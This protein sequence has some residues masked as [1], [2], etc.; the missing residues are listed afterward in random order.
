MGIWTSI[1]LTLGGILVSVVLKFSE[2]R[3]AIAKEKFQ[4]RL[5]AYEQITLYAYRLAIATIVDPNNQEAKEIAEEN[6]T[7][8]QKRWLEVLPLLPDKISDKVG[9]ILSKH[10]DV[11]KDGASQDEK[12]KLLGMAG[13]LLGAIKAELGTGTDIPTLERIFLGTNKVAR[14]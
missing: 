1:A 10:T 11:T 8:L 4:H 2:Y 6:W 3:F 7:L 12:N 13:D 5:L 14:T 9:D